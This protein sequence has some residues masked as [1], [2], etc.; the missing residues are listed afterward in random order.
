MPPR[1]PGAGP[2]PQP[3]TDPGSPAPVPVQ[4][5]KLTFSFKQCFNFSITFSHWASNALF[6]PVDQKCCVF[7][8][9]GVAPMSAIRMNLQR[10]PLPSSPSFHGKNC[11]R[12]MEMW[13]HTRRQ[14]LD[15][16]PLHLVELVIPRLRLFTHLF[17]SV[18]LFLVSLLSLVPLSAY[19]LPH[20]IRFVS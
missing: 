6:L 18:H 14:I 13:N 9:L 3:Q 20:Q 19:P 8:I 17:L 12:S 10:P 5:G 16:K 7:S 11:S 15:M 1:G 2:T 4:P